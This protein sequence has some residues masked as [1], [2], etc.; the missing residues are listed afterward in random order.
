MSSKM[1]EGSTNFASIRSASSVELDGSASRVAQPP[2]SSSCS[3]ECKGLPCSRMRSLIFARS[4]CSSWFHPLCSRSSSSTPSPSLRSRLSDA[5]SSSKTRW[6]YTP[7]GP[8]AC[9]ANSTSAATSSA[10]ASSSNCC[11]GQPRAAKP[12]SLRG[13]ST[14]APTS[15]AKS[16]S[17]QR[18]HGTQCHH[19][20]GSAPRSG[21]VLASTCRTCAVCCST[22]DS[23]V[24]ASNRPLSSPAPHTSGAQLERASGNQP[25]TVRTSATSSRRH[26]ASRHERIATPHS[27]AK[28]APSCCASASPPPPKSLTSDLGEAERRYSSTTASP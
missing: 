21:G 2:K 24:S 28:A 14:P 9:G 8:S 26:A 20:R 23:T 25:T 13:T 12:T 11:V 5:G 10:C 16:A 27:L 15:W 7:I 3:S 1:C 19:L 22:C 6:R 18:P 4:V 17:V